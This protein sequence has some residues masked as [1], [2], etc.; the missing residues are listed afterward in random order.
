[1]PPDTRLFD[2]IA[3]EAAEQRNLAPY[4]LKSAASMGRRF[5]EEADDLRTC[6]ERDRDR[7]VH[8][9]SFRR[10][11]YKTQVFVNWEGDHFRTRLSHS[12]EVCQVA[13]SAGADLGIIGTVLS[14]DAVEKKILRPAWAPDGTS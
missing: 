11:M 7:I 5:Q 13:R 6:W 3:K 12:L 2:R 9:T 14:S 4:G 8:C 1:M 10:L